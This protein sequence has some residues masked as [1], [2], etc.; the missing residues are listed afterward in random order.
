MPY[1]YYQLVGFVSMVV[2]TIMAFLFFNEKRKDG[3]YTLVHWSLQ[4]QPFIKIALE[5]MIKDT[6]DVIAGNR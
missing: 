4:F 6:V 1:G 3:R 5:R 2:L